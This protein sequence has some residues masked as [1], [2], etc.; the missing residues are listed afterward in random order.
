MSSLLCCPRCGSRNI[1]EVH[2]SHPVMEP[3]AG[4]EAHW[5]CMNCGE[6]C[7]DPAKSAL[8]SPKLDITV[9][10]TVLVSLVAVLGLLM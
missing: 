7:K 2:H 5:G 6:T 10:F 3:L 1:T 4:E 9:G 8:I